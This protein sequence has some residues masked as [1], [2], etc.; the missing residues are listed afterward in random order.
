M[1]KLSETLPSRPPAVEAFTEKTAALALAAYGAFSERIAANRVAA[2]AEE[3]SVEADSA[4]LK[5]AVSSKLDEAREAQLG[6][7]SQELKNTLKSSLAVPLSDLLQHPQASFWSSVRKLLTQARDSAR[8]FFPQSGIAF[9][10][11]PLSRGIVR[12]AISPRRIL[13]RRC[14]D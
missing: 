6:L 11:I 4:E 8:V 10:L 9:E 13:S 5:K 1:R 2:V 7:L 14:R 3:W 12:A